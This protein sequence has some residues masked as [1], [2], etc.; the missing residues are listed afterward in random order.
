MP[1]DGGNETVYP[2]HETLMAMF[3]DGINDTLSSSLLASIQW[4]IRYGSLIG[5]SLESPAW[6]QLLG[7]AEHGT[8]QWCA[9][10]ACGSTTYTVTWFRTD[11]EIDD[12][13][14]LVVKFRLV[15]AIQPF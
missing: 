15:D 9:S 1:T 6:K 13:C 8:Y 2:T 11:M 4:E 5:W 10:E 12:G 14:Q 7:D 3:F